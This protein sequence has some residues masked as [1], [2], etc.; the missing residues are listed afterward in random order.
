MRKNCSRTFARDSILQEPY[1]QLTA[2]DLLGNNLTCTQLPPNTRLIWH[3]CSPE[4]SLLSILVKMPESIVTTA[5]CRKPPSCTIALLLMC[6]S[7]HTGYIATPSGQDLQPGCL[8]LGEPT[9][10]CT[11]SPKSAVILRCLPSC[12]A[13]LTRL[14]ACYCM[15]SADWHV[16][17]KVHQ[18]VN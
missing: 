14:I 13:C 4:A 17:L 5:R 11:P 10:L 1:I 2:T 18:G 8:S 15:D 9:L 16:P 3:P 12:I 7:L 6:I